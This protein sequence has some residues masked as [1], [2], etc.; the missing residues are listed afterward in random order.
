MGQQ[1]KE[2]RCATTAALEQAQGVILK[3]RSPGIARLAQAML[4][5]GPGFFT[6]E[7]KELMMKTNPLTQLPHLWLLQTNIQLRLAE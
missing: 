5:I 2:A 3:Q 4:Q 1:V 7:G 6:A